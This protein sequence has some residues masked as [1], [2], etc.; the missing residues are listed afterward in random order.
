MRRPPTWKLRL[1]F[2]CKQLKG[3]E[4]GQTKLSIKSSTQDVI[5]VMNILLVL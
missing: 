3:F 5:I 2:R 4:G 1:D